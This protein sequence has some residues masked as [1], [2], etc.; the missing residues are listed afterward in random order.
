MSWL[1]SVLMA[2]W[3]RSITPDA[4]ARRRNKIATRQAERQQAATKRAI[5]DVGIR[6]GVGLRV[7]R[8]QE[9]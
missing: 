9:L 5:N 2:K 8:Q 6:G 7:A 3:V 1:L 4:Q